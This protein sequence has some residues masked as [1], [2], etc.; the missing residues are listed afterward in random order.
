LDVFRV[1][2]PQGIATMN[3]ELGPLP[4]TLPDSLS[5]TNRSAYAVM[6]VDPWKRKFKGEPRQ[7]EEEIMPYVA[8]HE[9][10]PEIAMNETRSITLMR[11]TGGL[12]A[13]SYEFLEMYCDEPKCDCR[14]VMFSV[15]SSARKDVEA[16][17]A[18]GW[19]SVDY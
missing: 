5:R 12:P 4:R 8:F 10:C 13:G 3:V 18:W 2:K 1:P 11:R 17:I 7:P 15:I 14:R 16:V 9:L 6:G 19:E